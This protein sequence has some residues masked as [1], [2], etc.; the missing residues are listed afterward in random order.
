[1]AEYGQVSPRDRHNEMLVANVHPPEWVNPKPAARYNLVV[2][3]AGT[4]GLVT[5]L[6]ATIVARHAGDMINE[7][8]AAIVNKIGL[9]SLANVIHSYPTQAEAVRQVGDMYTRT[10][11][12]PFVAKVFKLW[13]K[14]QR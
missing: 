13:L 2:I 5:A 14:W 10:R 12:T 6:G 3:G 7:L 4:A 8:S 11:L 9:G 1:M